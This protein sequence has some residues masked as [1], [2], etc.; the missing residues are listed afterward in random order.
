MRTLGRGQTCAVGVQP[1]PGGLSLLQGSLGWAEKM[2]PPLP[3]P[4]I[5]VWTRKVPRQTERE[6]GHFYTLSGNRAEKEAEEAMAEAGREKQRSCV[7]VLRVSP[8]VWLISK[9]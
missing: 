5:L 3:S 8:L 9:A 6:E 1:S 2:H 4:H 7:D